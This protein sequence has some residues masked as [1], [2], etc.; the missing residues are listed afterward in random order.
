[1]PAHRPFSHRLHLIDSAYLVG[2]VAVLV[3]VPG[4]ASLAW[5]ITASEYAALRCCAD[6]PSSPPHVSPHVPCSCA[7]GGGRHGSGG[8]QITD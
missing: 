6:Q 8:H 5:G 1:M 2:A 7:P 3:T 4:P